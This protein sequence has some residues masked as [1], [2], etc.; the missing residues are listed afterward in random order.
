MWKAC[1][2]LVA[3]AAVDA[4]EYTQL[5]SMYGNTF[6]LART[7]MF[8]NASATCAP[9]VLNQG[10]CGDCYSFST[11]TTLGTSACIQGVGTSTATHL[12]PQF[13]SGVKYM[14]Q[15][16]S[17]CTPNQS[18]CPHANPCAGGIPLLLMDDVALYC[19]R[20]P[21]QCWDTCDDVCET[22]TLP[23]TEYNCTDNS[24]LFYLP[25]GECVNCQGCNSFALP[26]SSG[27]QAAMSQDSHE[28]PLGILLSQP[29]PSL[30]NEPVLINS[31]TDTYQHVSAG[32]A[33]DEAWLAL[34]EDN[35]VTGTATVGRVMEWLTTRGPVSI[36]IDAG[37]DDF[38]QYFYGIGGFGLTT[39]NVTGCN[40]F[41]DHAV[42]IVGWSVIDGQPCW[43]VQNSWGTE[44]VGN[45]WHVDA[46]DAGF[47]HVPF[48]QVGF[49]GP[50]GDK[51]SNR[52][53][54]ILPTGSYF[55]NYQ[56][57]PTTSMASIRPPEDSRGRWAGGEHLETDPARLAALPS[58]ATAGMSEATGQQLRVLAVHN[59]TTQV[60][61]MVTHRVY[62]DVAP[63]GDD[64]SAQ[65]VAIAMA[66]HPT[67]QVKYIQHEVVQ[68]SGQTS[69]EN[70]EQPRGNSSS[71][72]DVGITI[73]VV[74]AALVVLIVLAFIAH[75][76][77]RQ[78]A[79]SETA[80]EE[81]ALDEAIGDEWI[82]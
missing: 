27:P 23:Y 24:S 62:C 73:G 46:V 53:T 2:I 5:L 65:T 55:V 12:S 17:W 67:G 68:Q 13:T 56:G 52:F 33:S 75:G 32:L 79:R 77:S 11:A 54:M 4:G 30:A 78:V 80:P 47:F 57:T 6:N 72:S 50:E 3:T 25:I 19:D 61:G 49:V 81:Q 63:V 20:N 40:G 29:V 21:S 7:G 76:R 35:Q 28:L 64:A 1:L 41:A 60:T 16:F 8:R 82:E 26:D 34:S 45:G 22:G 14:Q 69:A 37:C 36:A 70:D 9:P 59:V 31:A 10:E 38:G 66:R 58:Y 39:E 74:V 44:Y 71:G 51:M 42:T 48:S 15:E 18:W 43:T